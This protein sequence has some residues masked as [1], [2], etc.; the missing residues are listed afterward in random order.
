MKRLSGRAA[1]PSSSSRPRCWWPHRPSRRAPLGGDDHLRQEL[2][3]T[4]SNSR[5]IW[6]LYQ[7]QTGGTWKLVE[8]KSWRAGSGLPGKAGRNSCATTKGWLPN[9]TYRVR[10]YNNYRGNVI[11]GRAFRLD[12]KACANG[13]GAAP[14]CSS[15]PSRAPGNRQC[16]DRRG[17]QV[18][19]WEWP[20]FNDYKSFGCIKMAPG[21]LAQL[22]AALP[23]ALRRRRAL[24]DGPGGPARRQLRPE[25][26]FTISETRWPLA[27]LLADLDVAAGAVEGQRRLV[28]RVE[29]DLEREHRPAAAALELV[30]DLRAEA[31]TPEVLVDHDAVEVAEVGVALGEPGEVRPRRTPT[32]P[33]R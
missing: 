33:R 19:R 7:R 15:T 20:R 17:D 12:D 9:G 24:P 18:C 8:T 16:A 32:R 14:T 10:Q 30:V 28:G 26:C 4:S 6:R 13:N 1:P 25:Q 31:A 22:R 11:K 29:V 27:S 2:A 23:P 3:A 21:D 5:L